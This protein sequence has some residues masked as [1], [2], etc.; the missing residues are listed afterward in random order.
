MSEQK[1]CVLCGKPRPAGAYK[2][3]EACRK[4]LKAERDKR[5]RLKQA[6]AEREDA[7]ADIKTCILCG[8]PRPKGATK[9][10]EACRA[11][12]VKEQGNHKH[13]KP[14]EKAP[15]RP[16]SE[17]VNCKGCYYWRYMHGGTNACYYAIDTE[18][19]RHMP[20]AD[21]YKHDGTPYRPKRK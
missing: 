7:K 14:V 16:K 15:E 8:A 13:K 6:L 2:F 10:C 3:C 9:Y 1:F 4:K 12:K 20:A 5:V 19:L 18:K 21:C 17:V 11:K